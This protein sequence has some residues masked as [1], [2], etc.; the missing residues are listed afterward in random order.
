M[1]TLMQFAVCAALAG[2]LVGAKL[3]AQTSARVAAKSSAAEPME[4]PLWPGV[5]PGSEGWTWHE[6]EY[7]TPRRA[8]DTK[9]R[10]AH[11]DCVL[12]GSRD[13]HWGCHHRCSRRR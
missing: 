3:T 2:M 1:R 5:A 12:A 9:H 8:R 7:Q 10:Q 4:I 13:S 11:A 6:Q